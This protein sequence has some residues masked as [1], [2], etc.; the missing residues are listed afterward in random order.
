MPMLG[1]RTQIFISMEFISHSRPPYPYPP[2]IDSSRVRRP[3]TPPPFL[4]SQAPTPPPTRPRKPPASLLHLTTARL[5]QPAPPPAASSTLSSLPLPHSTTSL[6]CCFLTLGEGRDLG[7]G[8]PNPTLG[9]WW[10]AA[11]V[12][13]VVV[14][15]TVE[16]GG[17]GRRRP[18]WQ[19]AAV[20]DA[21]LSLVVA[22]LGDG[23][24]R[25]WQARLLHHH[26][27]EG[28]NV[29]S[30]PPPPRPVSP[31]TS[32]ARASPHCRRRDPVP[33]WSSPWTSNSSLHVHPPGTSPAISTSR[34]FQPS[35]R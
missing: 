3:R 7:L 29:V 11:A 31:S 19:A 20:L 10:W 23:G 13:A 15:A 18:W 35:C 9:G 32:D 16:G 14:T 26:R 5:L 1:S 4:S 30:C 25:R 34:S 12:V 21:L 28:N 2:T 22:I 17:G 8:A 24:A 27:G 6:R 33:R